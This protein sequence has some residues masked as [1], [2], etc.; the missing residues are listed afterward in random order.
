MAVRRG[1]RRARPPYSG[2]S[3]RGARRSGVVVS[4]PSGIFSDMMRPRNGRV[5][6]APWIRLSLRPN[7]AGCRRY[8]QSAT[9]VRSRLNPRWVTSLIVRL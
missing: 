2:A 1:R 6:V 8:H 4:T 5:G 7:V 3:S 9:R